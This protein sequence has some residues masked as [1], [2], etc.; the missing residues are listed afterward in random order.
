MSNISKTILSAVVAAASVCPCL[1]ADSSNSSSNTID[2]SGKYLNVKGEYSYYGTAG[3][4]YVVGGFNGPKGSTANFTQ[5]GNMQGGSINSQ[6][7]FTGSSAAGGS[8]SASGNT[9]YN[10]FT[11]SGTHTGS[12]SGTSASGQSYGWNTTTTFSSGNGF[13]SNISTLNNGTY[14][15]SGSKSAGITVTAM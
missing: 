2:Y 1:A 8:A 7:T 14:T 3:Q 11:G 12:G 13:N 6:S 4:S 10:M 9:T 5:A 15:V